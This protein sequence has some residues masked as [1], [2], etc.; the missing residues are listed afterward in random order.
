MDKFSQNREFF[1]ADFE[2]LKQIKTD[3]QK[4]IPAPS[5]QKEYNPNS[6]LIEL[7]SVDK[8]ILVKPNILDCINDRRSVRK[9]GNEK[10]TLAELSYLLWAT[11]GIQ[12]VKDKS[13]ALRTVP[14]AGCTHPFETYLIINNVENLKCGVY[15]Y[16]PLEHKLLLIKSLN[17]VDDAID[18]ATPN[19]PFVQGF[20]SKSAVVFAWSCIPYR[21]EHKFNITAHKKILIDIGHVCQNLYIASES[22]NHG[23]CAIGIYDQDIIDNMLDL[24]GVDEFVIYMACVGKKL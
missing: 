15:R 14:S 2:I 13:S 7:P 20:V 23:T 6:E 4:G 19:Q 22:L 10:I 8:D 3:K 17:N 9:Y 16:L 11:Q 18:K 1:K 5:F 12:T 24:D 21:S